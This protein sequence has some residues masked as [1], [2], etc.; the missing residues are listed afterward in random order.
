MK[1]PENVLDRFLGVGEFLP[2]S[3]MAGHIC[4]DVVVVN[5]L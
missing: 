4:V 2:E 1:H 5:K 3:D